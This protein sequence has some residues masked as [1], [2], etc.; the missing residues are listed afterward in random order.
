MKTIIQEE[1]TNYYK[2]FHFN[3]HPNDLKKNLAALTIPGNPPR[4]LK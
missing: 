1:A 3:L 4:C 2:L